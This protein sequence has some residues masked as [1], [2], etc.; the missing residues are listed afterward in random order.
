MKRK[1]IGRKLLWE[2]EFITLIL[3]VEGILNTRP[4]TYASFDG[5]KVIRPANF[6][7]PNASVVIPTTNDNQ[8]EYMSGTLNARKRLIKYWVT[9]LK[10]LDTFWELWKTKYLTSLKE[11]T[12][13]PSR[14]T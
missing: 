6:I 13:N 2:K 11:R 1:A 5:S 9:T 4:L 12:V 7:Q 14:S 3:E 10:V 8:D